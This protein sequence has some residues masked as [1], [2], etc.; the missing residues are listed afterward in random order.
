MAFTM[1]PDK[2]KL[3]QPTKTKDDFLFFAP[4]TRQVLRYL[5]STPFI[6]KYSKWGEIG[7]GIC[8]RQ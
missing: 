7:A 6:F 5:L 8:P 1:R 4:E 2:M 3:T